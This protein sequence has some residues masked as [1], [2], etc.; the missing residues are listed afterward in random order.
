MNLPKDKN[1][2]NLSK[3]NIPKAPRLNNDYTY[4]KFKSRER[5]SIEQLI[6]KNY[7]YPNSRGSKITSSSSLSQRSGSRELYVNSGYCSNE[8]SENENEQMNKQI[9]VEEKS[10]NKYLSRSKFK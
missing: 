1:Y 7:N 9:A 3:P 4:Q 2:I 5:F 10:W 6:S 8:D